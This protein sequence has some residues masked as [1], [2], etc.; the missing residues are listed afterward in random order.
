MKLIIFLSLIVAGALVP[1]WAKGPAEDSYREACRILS[2]ARR[3]WQRK[4]SDLAWQRY[5]EAEKL[6]V[7]I[8]RDYPGWN[9][10]AVAA[11]LAVCT[12]GGEKTAPHIIREL[13][14]SILEL[15]RFSADLDNLRTQ[16][17]IALQQADWEYNF[18]YDR[19]TKLV[20]DY[21]ARRAVAGEIAPL[22]PAAA[23]GVGAALGGLG[24]PK[25]GVAVELESDGDE[26]AD[27][28]SEDGDIYELITM[29]KGDYIAQLIVTEEVVPMG[30]V[31]E[32]EDLAMALEAEGLTET[33]ITVGFDSDD[34]GLADEVELEMGTLPSDPDTDKDG[35]YDGDEVEMGYDPLDDSSHPSVDEVSDYDEDN[36]DWSEQDGYDEAGVPEGDS[37][38]QP[39]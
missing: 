18:I 23:E 19:I 15:K 9:T 28:D 7:A 37:D 10:E 8:R 31:S 27:A 39:N 30:L 3:A 13:D 33:E 2:E 5:L 36:I 14:R 32:D 17:L 29:L 4:E 34:D 6:F 25:G 12:A 22:R 35:F 1:A 11:H 20:V 21:I 38:Y 26:L 16:K 24:L